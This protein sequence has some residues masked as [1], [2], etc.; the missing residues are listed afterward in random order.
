LQW[1]YTDQVAATRPGVT[2]QDLVRLPKDGR[3]YELVDG[4]IRVS[5]AGARHGQVIVRLTVRLGAFVAQERLGEVFDSS[6][7]YRLPGGNVRSPDASFVSSKRLPRVPEGFLEL[8]P[9]LAVEVLSPEDSPRGV[10]DKVGE[11]LAAGVQLV[12]VID[13]RAS[14]AVSYRSLTDVHVIGRA[15]AL[16]GEDVLPGFRCPLADLLG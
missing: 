5:P 1:A 7:G 6:T 11:Y 13:P 14:R 3:K 15:G 2:D 10:L 8:A 16:D 9:D 12:W 4:E